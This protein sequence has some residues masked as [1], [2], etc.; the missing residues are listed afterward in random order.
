LPRGAHVNV[1]EGEAVVAGDPLMDGPIDPHDI[2]KVKGADELQ[3]Y[4]VDEIQ[5][6]YRLQGVAINDKHIEVI[7]RQM[8]RWVKIEE[9]GDSDFLVDEVVDF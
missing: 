7:G 4:L 8:M 3:R 6:V 2:L 5:E 1:R 9:V